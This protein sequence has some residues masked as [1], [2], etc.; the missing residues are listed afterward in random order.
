[1]L[2]KPAT[3]SKFP[4]TVKLKGFDVPAL[5]VTVSDRRP[6]CA[7]GSTVNIAVNAVPLKTL[8]EL[9]VTPVPVTASVVAP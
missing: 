7:A 1:M 6:A 3:G 4:I 5:V 9:P 2:R 8:T